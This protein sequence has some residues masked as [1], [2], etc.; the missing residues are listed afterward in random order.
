MKLQLNPEGNPKR[1]N[2]SQTTAVMNAFFAPQIL[3]ASPSLSPSARITAGRPFPTPSNASTEWAS[4]IE[5]T[6]RCL[7]SCTRPPHSARA[8]E[9][10]RAKPSQRHPAPRRS[11]RHCC[12]RTCSPPSS[13]S[14]RVR[15]AQPEHANNGEQNLPNA[16]KFLNGVGG[17]AAI[18]PAARCLKSCTR[19]PRSARAREDGGQNLPNAL[20][21]LD[22][23]G[24]AAT[25]ALPQILYASASLSPSPRM[26]AGKP[27][28]RHPAPWRSGRHCN[29][30]TCSPLP[31][32][33]YA[34]PSLSPS[35]RRTAGKTFPT[36]SNASTEWASLLQ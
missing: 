29:N 15:L 6:A 19:R 2:R 10:R 33:L 4:T 24:I 17:T 22:G 36:P 5:F 3:Y 16:A 28:Q 21:R 18:E 34:S 9:E 31:H 32:I 23:V 20:Q 1:N 27:S 35:A 30:R 13:A 8:R 11:G 26:T 14:V 7:K 25:I 12:N